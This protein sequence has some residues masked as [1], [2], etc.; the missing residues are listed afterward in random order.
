MFALLRNATALVHP[1]P[2]EGFGLPVI[3]AMSM[4]VPVITAEGGAA[5]EAAAGRRVASPPTD[6]EKWSQ[7]WTK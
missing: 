3:E 2:I 6:P 1:C 7:P 5:P 4:A